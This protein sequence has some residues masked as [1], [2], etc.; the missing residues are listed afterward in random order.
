VVVVVVVVVVGAYKVNSDGGDVA[1]GVS[2]VSEPEQ[3]AR[4]AHAGVADQQQLEQVITEEWFGWGGQNWVNAIGRGRS[5]WG[6]KRG[7]LTIRPAFFFL[8]SRRRERE[9]RK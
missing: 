3:Q 9:V 4:L 5:D 8:R 2:V 7:A 6:H 1:L